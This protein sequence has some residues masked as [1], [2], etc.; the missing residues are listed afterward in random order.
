MLVHRRI[1]RLCSTVAVIITFLCIG[2]IAGFQ[3]APRVTQQ[4]YLESVMPKSSID[5]RSD[6][7]ASALKATLWPAACAALIT[8]TSKPASA[9]EG[10][11]DPLVQ[12][13]LDF[14]GD[15]LMP[16]VGD[17]FLVQVF[18]SSASPP[19]LLAG[20][21]LPFLASVRMPFRFQ[22]F[23]ENLMIP[24]KKWTEMGE[25]E[26][27]V[28]VT[29]CHG[30]IG[31]GGVCTGQCLAKGAGIS[32]VVSIGSAET[33]IRPVRL[34]ALIKLSTCKAACIQPSADISS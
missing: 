26:Q 1:G 13:I 18:D 3:P 9:A 29:L 15:A 24:E 7:I 10:E 4:M 5:G 6:L 23:K 31:K 2:I 22:L 17:N 8:M 27:L 11:F 19:L 30:S 32:K 14:S 20:A 33:E 21:K 12:G 28:V 34:F 16:T 25:F